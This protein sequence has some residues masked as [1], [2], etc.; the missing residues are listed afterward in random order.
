[1]QA[2]V[3]E[4]ID[5]LK[6]DASANVDQVKGKVSEVKNNIESDISKKKDH[7]EEELSAKK[8]VLM[9]EAGKI[10]DEIKDNKN[11]FNSNIGA[12]VNSADILKT[13]AADT[14]RGNELS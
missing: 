14:A 8:A 5:Q 1:M 7:I 4:N 12:V 10:E 6:A 13:A 9:E 3:S 11:Q 2:E